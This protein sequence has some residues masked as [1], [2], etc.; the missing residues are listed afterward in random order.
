[1]IQWD[2]RQCGEGIEVP[3]SLASDAVECP[4]CGVFSRPPDELLPKV[5][6]APDTPTKPKHTKPP[7]YK[8]T[9][10]N[11]FPPPPNLKSKR[12]ASSIRNAG[13][14]LT[15][16]GLALCAVAFVIPTSINGTHNVGLLNNRTVFAVIASGV[17]VSGALIYGIGLATIA[18]V[19][20]IQA[21]P[22]GVSHG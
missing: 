16:I 17:L 8:P 5:R 11:P 3:E 6:T 2:C 1:M 15:V 19:Q 7:K 13:I 22:E 10:L 4:Q 20:A 9:L 21:T 18:I 14:V 12:Q